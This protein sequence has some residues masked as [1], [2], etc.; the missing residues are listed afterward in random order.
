M[1]E[2]SKEEL[3]VI[4]QKLAGMDMVAVP[5]EPTEEMKAAGLACMNEAGVTAED[6]YQ[7]MLL[8]SDKDLSV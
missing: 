3:V 8:A 4:K 2:S 6:I 1:I 5:I 7:S